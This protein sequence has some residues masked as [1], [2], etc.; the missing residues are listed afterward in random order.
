MKNKYRICIKKLM[1]FNHKYGRFLKSMCK[2]KILL[3]CLNRLVRK[4]T[5]ISLGFNHQLTNFNLHNVPNALD[6]II[7]ISRIM[8][9]VL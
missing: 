3:V 6:K 2:I 1:K 9:L 5:Q 7:L 8:L 4:I